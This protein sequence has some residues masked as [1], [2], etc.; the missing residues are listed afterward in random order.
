MSAICPSICISAAL[1]S[2]WTLKVVLLA[3]FSVDPDLP[4]TVPVTFPVN[5]PK[6]FVACT[7]ANLFAEVPMFLLLIT[8]GI[9]SPVVTLP[10]TFKASPM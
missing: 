4:E 7:D 9:M 1:T 8:C 5:S 6:I 2:P 10:A 3:S